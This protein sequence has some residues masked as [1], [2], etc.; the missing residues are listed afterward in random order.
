MIN[1][2]L[3][4]AMN[5]NICPKC[6]MGWMEFKSN[7]TLRKCVTCGFTIVVK[8]PTIKRNKKCK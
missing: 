6:H 2:Q 8:K 4:V 1:Q 7:N 3:N 5:D